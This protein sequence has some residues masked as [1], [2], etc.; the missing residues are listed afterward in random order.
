MRNLV[1]IVPLLGM[2]VFHSLLGAQGPVEQ[3]LAWQD[4]TW[5]HLFSDED[6][7]L[8]FLNQVLELEGQIPDTVLANSFNHLA[9]HHGLRYENPEARDN[10]QRAFD[11]MHGAPRRQ[12]IIARNLGLILKDLDDFD[13]SLAK[14][15]AARALHDSLGDS[16]QLAMDFC[17]L[18][19]LHASSELVKEA[20]TYYNRGLDLF[21]LEN[22]RERI[23]YWV[24]QVNLG[25]IYIDSGQNEFAETLFRSSAD[26]L[27]EA[28]RT[29]QSVQARVNLINALLFQR[30][31]DEAAVEFDRIATLDWEPSPTL[32]VHRGRWLNLQG[33]HAEAYDLLRTVDPA[34]LEAF[35]NTGYFFCQMLIALIEL[36]RLPEALTMAEQV[37]LT[38]PEAYADFGGELQSVQIWEARIRSMLPGAT[39]AEKRQAELIDGLQALALRRLDNRAGI[40]QGRFETEYLRLEQAALAERNAH[41]AEINESSK[42]RNTALATAVGLL[43][44]ALLLLLGL[45]RTRRRLARE[46][47]ES[48]RNAADLSQ[49]QAELASIQARQL[50][51]AMKIKERELVVSAMDLATLQNKVTQTITE[52]QA[53]NLN[54]PALESL[55]RSASQDEFF[56]QFKL[57]FQGIHP[58]FDAEMLRRFPELTAND[59]EFCQLLKLGLSNREIGELLN[60]SS[61]SVMTRKYRL[62]K[63][64]GLDEGER[65]ET[66]LA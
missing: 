56:E 60:I 61:S 36:D 29:A 21:N 11:L 30:K 4:S 28:G 19:S 20:I 15:E 9:I 54:H 48:A 6:R 10:F 50:G 65:I 31:L 44:A 58:D 47:T 62:R 24:E 16:R 43:S 55:R 7:A 2:L 42:R 37:R 22:P 32:I 23:S 64:M 66:H 8:G 14:I 52:L 57:R 45:Y 12:A 27:E 25:F 39:S 51:D 35:H 34:E 26:G 40:L 5:S 3:A 1:R 38:Y 46:L 17:A 13:A 49:K 63:R 33:Q 59:L 18:G 41:L 53:A